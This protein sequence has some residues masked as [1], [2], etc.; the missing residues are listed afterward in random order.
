MHIA[1]AATIG[2][3]LLL[4]F[5]DARERCC[6]QRALQAIRPGRWRHAGGSREDVD[7]FQDE[8]AGKRTAKVGDAMDRFEHQHERYCAAPRQ[9]RGVRKAGQ[10]EK[11][12]T[13]VARR[14]M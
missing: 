14:V 1:S 4:G 3:A 8:E 10:R 11:A 12:D 5:C 2:T 6:D 7:Q 9:A 13:Y